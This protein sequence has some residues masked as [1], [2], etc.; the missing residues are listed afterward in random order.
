M[1]DIPVLT[2]PEVAAELR[3]SRT[4]V[5]NL[6]NGKVR[7]ARPLPSLRLGRRRLVLRPTLDD[8]KKASE[9]C[10]YPIIA[11][12]GRRRMHQRTSCESGISKVV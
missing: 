2:V 1:P 11:G 5:F 3:C 10:Y 7:G 12:H 4:H 8:W 6:I 9:E